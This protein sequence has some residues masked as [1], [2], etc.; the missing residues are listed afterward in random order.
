MEA[1]ETITE[2]MQDE[3]AEEIDRRRAGIKLYLE[4]SRIY[5]PAKP[6]AIG[7]YPFQ[8][9]FHNAGADHPERCLISANRIGKTQ[10]AAAET[11]CH[12]TG[13]YPKW[14]KGRRFDEP[15][16][17]WTGAERT[18]DSKEVVQLALLGPE[19]EHG[20]GWIPRDLIEKVTYR[21]SGVSSVVDQIFVRHVTGG[22]SVVTLKTYQMEAKGWRGAKLH[23]VWP[24]EEPKQDIYT[25]CQTRLMDLKGIIYMTFTPL[26]GPTEVVQH[27]LDAEEGSGIYV[28]NVSWDD[29]PHLDEAEKKRLWNSYPAHERD[30]RARG[31]PMLGSGAIFPIGDDEISCNPFEIPAHFYRING[32][33]FGI[34]H[35]GAGVFMAW[36]KDGGTIY[37]YD[38]YKIAGQTSLYHATAMQK[39]GSWIPIAWPHD[40]MIRDKG[41]SGP[42]LKDQFRGHGAHMLREHAHYLDERGNH[43]EPGVIELYEWMRLGKLKIFRTL[44]QLFEEKRLY[45][46]KN[47]EIVTKKD[48]ILSAL[49]Y[50]FIMRRYARHKP[51]LIMK[52]PRFTR[53]IV[54]GRKWRAAV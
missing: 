36:D 5:D 26:L 47:G 28:K 2:E 8:A 3:A 40:G 27:F 24:D 52:K 25:E 31:T 6:E 33:D 19:G 18:E 4:Y 7:A 12:L 15:T 11:A 39:H 51:A 14:W 43:R 41:N 29:A 54:G 17:G 44:Q 20:T 53:P 21:Q 35:P 9:E 16:R 10:C 34:D 49:R 23:F 37:V 45:H 1:E 32:V 38:C 42:A 30:A 48:D 13:L 46:R 50:A 22:T